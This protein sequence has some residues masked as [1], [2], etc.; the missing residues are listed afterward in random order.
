MNEKDVDEKKA[1]IKER[2]KEEKKTD[3]GSAEIEVEK[4]VEV[5]GRGRGPL[6]VRTHT[7][8]LPLLL[9]LH[10]MHPVSP[11]LT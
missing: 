6:K 10:A 4:E 5:S 9:H 2:V 11:L 1:N 3:E 7:P 8:I